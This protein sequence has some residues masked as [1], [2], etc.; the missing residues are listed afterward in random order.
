M[1]PA[2]L[3]TCTAC[4]RE[5]EAEPLRCECGARRFIEC[6]VS[7]LRTRYGVGVSVCEVDNTVYDHGKAQ[8]A[9]TLWKERV[10]AT[11]YCECCPEAERTLNFDGAPLASFV[12]GVLTCDDCKRAVRSVRYRGYPK[13]G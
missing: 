9:A 5:Y 2:R 4:A 11:A 1:T 3:W 10:A 13:P 8:R 6:E 12:D 7:T